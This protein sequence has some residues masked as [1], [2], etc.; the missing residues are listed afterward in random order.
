MRFNAEKVAAW[1]I[2]IGAI[3]GIIVLAKKISSPGGLTG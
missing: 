2:I 3:P 1:I